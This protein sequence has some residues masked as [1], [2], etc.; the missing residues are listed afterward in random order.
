MKH[1]SALCALGALS[2]LSLSAV[3]APPPGHPSVD[4]AST[5]APAPATPFLTQKAKV[6]TVVDVRN[7]TYLEV[8]MDQG[9]DKK[10]VWLAG[11][12]TPVKVGATV[13]FDEGMPMQ[14]FHSESLNRT[15]ED[16]LFVSYIEVAAE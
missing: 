2:L 6:L 11:P 8:V 14:D 1:I 12:T 7:Y 15:F 13:H 16:I 5:K 10:P 9:A 4:E 3:A